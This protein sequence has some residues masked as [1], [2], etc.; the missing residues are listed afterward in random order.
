MVR[1]V[2]IFSL[3]AAATASSCTSFASVVQGNTNS[4][5]A[6]LGIP[7]CAYITANS[8]AICNTMAAWDIANSDTCYLKGP[9]YGCTINAGQF[10]TTV[11]IYCQLGPAAPVGT[12][13]ASASGSATNTPSATRTGTPSNSPTPSNVP[14]YYFD[15]ITDFNGVQGNNGWTYGFYTGNGYP[16]YNLAGR[17]G[18]PSDGTIQQAWLY[19]PSCNGW[20]SNYELMPNDGMNC[21]TPSCSSVKPSILWTNPYPVAF[22]MKIIVTLQALENCGNGVQMNLA[23]NG[24][25]IWNNIVNY[26]M[27]TQRITYI[28]TY[29]NSVELTGQPNFGCNCA[30]M[31]YHIALIPVAATPSTTSTASL[32]GSATRSA[33]ASISANGSATASLSALASISATGSTSIS[34]SA[35]AT[36]S[37]SGSTSVS[38]SPV[39]TPSASGSASVS[40]SPVAS[41]SGSGSASASATTSTTETSTL[42]ATP[43]PSQTPT[44]SLTSSITP[45]P[46]PTSSVTPSR[47]I[48]PTGSITPTSS[49]TGSPSMNVTIIYENAPMSKGVIAAIAFS[50]IFG[51]LVAIVCCGALGVMLRRS[52]P[53]TQT[54]AERRPSTIERRASAVAE[55]RASAVQRSASIVAVV[56]RRDSKASE[57][58]RNSIVASAAERRK[59]TLELRAVEVQIEKKDLT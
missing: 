5:P 52:P 42:T 48:T 26:G 49:A 44:I 16:N 17:Y 37:A 18:L 28:G 25:T 20:V 59:S 27:G 15:S 3:V 53:P 56:E 35:I 32:T 51:I 46:S 58:R 30:H 54:V 45:T 10:S 6:G 47:S 7:D 12:A 4:P 2:S 34:L 24:G 1:L 57:P 14:A 40:L 29:V 33:F 31:S 9:G 13:T 55:R 36:S 38:L 8:A 19:N 50:S 43:T 22:Y 21:N 11:A 41:P 39:A 23:V